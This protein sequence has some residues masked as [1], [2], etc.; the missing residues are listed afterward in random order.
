MGTGPH[1][2]LALVASAT[3]P[4]RARPA[5]GRDRFASPP[6][7]PPCGSP[8]PA[9]ESGQSSTCSVARSGT[10]ALVMPLRFL[11]SRLLLAVLSLWGVSVLVVRDPAHP[12]RRSGHPHGAGRLH[13]AGHRARPAGVRPDRILVGAVQGLLP[14]PLPR[15]LRP[16]ALAP[17]GRAPRDPGA[18]AG[19]ARAG[20]DRAR[21]RHRRRHPARRLLGVAAPGLARVRRGVAG[22]ARHRGAELRLG[23]PAHRRVRRDPPAPAGLRAASRR[24][25]RP[26]R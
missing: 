1:G 14:E 13:R 23:P 26:P 24:S 12:A 16:L 3:R 15:E 8:R 25:T 9:L 6:G 17:A 22:D 7:S 20:A 5:P 21:A 18:A 2:M 4:A 11:L 10:R 19:H